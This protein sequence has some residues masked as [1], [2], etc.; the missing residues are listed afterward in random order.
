MANRMLRVLG[1]VVSLLLASASAI[2]AQDDRPAEQ[3]YANIKVMKGVPASQIA[4]GMHLI[5]AAL[6]VDCTHCH[7]EMHFDRDVPM[8][9]KARAMYTMMVQINRANFNGEQVVTCYT[10]H[11]GKA[12]PDTIPAV[13]APPL[14]PEGGAAKAVLPTVDQVVAKYI[15]AL[16]GE[17][18]LRKVTSRVIT[19]SLDIPTGPGGSVLVPA[20][21]VR[22][23]KE[24]NLFV[25]VYKTDK[26]T[27][28]N[29]FDGTAAWARGQLGNVNSPAPGGVDAERARRAAAFYEPLTL[30][31]QYPAMAVEGIE[32]INGHD[33][34]VVTGTPAMNTPERLYFDSQT[35]LL[36]R[37]WT[38]VVAVSGK[39]P[40]QVDFDDYRDTG[41][42]VKVPFTVRI[43][44]AG[45]RTVLQT[46]S[47]LRI[48]KVQDNVPV[49]AAVFVKPE[50]PPRPPAAPRQ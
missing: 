17:Q 43:S 42:G 26:F 47:T 15:A 48:V 44:P 40:Y 12:I 41:S 29:G 25:D 45:Q 49:D 16:G 28:S 50:P 24:P 3:V 13:P 30:K 46:T 35:G 20:T 5:E 39:S 27:I 2:S 10:C 32:R 38:Y 18:A 19:G 36:L 1:V 8:K 11:K 4:Q 22:T 21:L 14:A 31:Q 7:V 37:K 23:M 6:G 34:Y 33:A 9:E